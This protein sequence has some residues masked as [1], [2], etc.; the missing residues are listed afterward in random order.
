MALSNSIKGIAAIVFAVTFGFLSTYAM[1]GDRI[2]GFLVS[3][4][5]ALIV[6][7]LKLERFLEK[8]N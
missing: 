4:L 6:L 3:Q 5:Y 1:T 2:L 8:P 7:G